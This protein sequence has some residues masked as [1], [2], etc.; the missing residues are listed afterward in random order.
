M[1]NKTDHKSFSICH[2]KLFSM[3]ANQYMLAYVEE[4]DEKKNRKVMDDDDD[5]VSENDSEYFYNIL[6]RLNNIDFFSQACR[7]CL[8]ES[9]FFNN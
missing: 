8:I 7:L 9:F 6:Y 4:M 5:D 2:F 1:I 3:F